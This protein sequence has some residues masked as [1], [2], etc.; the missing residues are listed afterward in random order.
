MRSSRSKTDHVVPGARE[1]LR[2]RQPRRAGAHDG[3]AL[4]RARARWLRH[5]RPAAM[6]VVGDA[7][8]RSP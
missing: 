7:S 5:E 2:G 8:A 1:L 4:P 6:R 3:D